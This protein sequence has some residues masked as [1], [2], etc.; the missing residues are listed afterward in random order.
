VLLL[1]LSLSCSLHRGGEFAHHRQL[2]LQ[3]IET[4]SKR[5]QLGEG[6]SCERPEK[7]GEQLVSPAVQGEPRHGANDRE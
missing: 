6:K 2:L 3:L 5:S 1:A 4:G 7:G